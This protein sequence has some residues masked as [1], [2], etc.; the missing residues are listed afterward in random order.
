MKRRVGRATFA[1][2]GLVAIALLGASASGVAAPAA[3]LRLAKVGQFERPLYTATAPGRP[4]L[5]FVVE[6]SGDIRVVRDGRVVHRSFLDLRDRVLDDHSEQGMYSIAFDPGYAHNRRFY[7]YFVN[8]D[9]NI[10]VDVL[11]RSKHDPARADAGSL[12]TVIVIPHPD[13]IYYNGGGLQFGPDG[14]LY[15]GTG[16]GQDA[17]GQ[18]AEGNSQDAQSLLGKLLR[19]DPKPGGGYSVPDSNPFSGAASLPEIYATGL[20]NP[21]RFTFDPSEGDIWI[22]DVGENRWEEVDRVDRADL[23][24]VNFGWKLFEG[25]HPYSGDGTEP[26]HYEPPVFEY[27]SFENHSCAILG[28]TV[29]HEPSLGPLDGDYLY[30]DVCAGRL[31]HFDPANP[32]GTDARTRMKVKLPTSINSVAGGR[33]YVT[34][35][36]G[37]LYR[38]RMRG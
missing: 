16:D 2:A 12:Q 34:S 20:R 11:R 13:D 37:G 36:D 23:A 35:L 7:V 10:E 38:V 29:V 31:R 3:K 33:V 25:N 32:A 22:A 4:S 21:Y 30:S 14:L 15:L 19:I 1:V 5:L 28:G 17:G 26:P 24:G 27:S 6:Q 8:N 18:S 9:S